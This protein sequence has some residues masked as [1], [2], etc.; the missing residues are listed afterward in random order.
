MFYSRL[1]I[2]MAEVNKNPFKNYWSWIGYPGSELWYG[3][4]PNSNRLFFEPH[5]NTTKKIS[6]I[7]VYNLLRYTANIVSL[8]SICWLLENGSPPKSRPRQCCTFQITDSRVTDNDL[9][10]SGATRSRSDATLVKQL[11]S[12]LFGRFM[13]PVCSTV[14]S[15]V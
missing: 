2:G 7:S 3:S 8:R 5:S 9:C 1:S 11:R 15:K 12:Q 14:C 10:G 13:S 6:T 4:P